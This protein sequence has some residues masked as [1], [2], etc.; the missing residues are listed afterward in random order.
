MNGF[1]RLIDRIA[2][3]ILYGVN[4]DMSDKEF[5]EQSIMRWKNSPE[6]HMQIKGHLYYDNE[7]DIL[8]RKRTMIGEDGKLQV[9]ENLPN[10]RNIDNQYAKMVNQK[11]NYLLGNPF[12]IETDNEQYSELL[13]EVFNKKFMRTLKKSGKYA[14]NGGIAWLYPYYDEEGNLKFRLFPSYEILP[15][16]EDSEHTKMQGAVRLYLV[17]GYEKNIPVVI[18]KVEI[19]DMTGI[20]RYILDGAT[21]IPDVTVKEQDS[22]YVTMT[23]GDRAAEGLNWSRIPLIPLKRNELETPLIKNVKTL[24]DG[25][26]V[27]LSDFEN[28]MQEDAR[29]TILVLKNYD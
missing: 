4:G 6:R 18:E 12:T 1:N 23:D 17:A 8:M 5:L 27:M 21:L 10:N 19:F 9:V 24:Q 15:F 11:S 14:L 20:H 25:I 7:H 13:K 16:W 3:F 26:N 29:N 22:F 28:N 2:H